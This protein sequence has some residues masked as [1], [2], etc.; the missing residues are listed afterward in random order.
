ME[1]AGIP[2]SDCHTR[3]WKAVPRTSSG[4]SRPCAGASTKPTTLASNCSKSSSPPTSFA[5]GKRSWRS[6]TRASGASPKRMAET[7]SWLAATRIEPSEHSPTA[8]RID[9]P[10]PPARKPAARHAQQLRIGC[11]EPP[12]GIVVAGVSWQTLLLSRPRGNHGNLL[13]GCGAPM[14]PPRPI[15]GDYAAADTP[16]LAL[17][18]KMSGSR[19]LAPARLQFRASLAISMLSSRTIYKVAMARDQCVRGGKAAISPDRGLKIHQRAG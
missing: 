5:L 10:L 2:Q 4:R 17:K 9:V 16:A 1:P 12:A 7:P 6:R 11:V 18:F 13:F 8:K 14:G 15:F 3:S 19:K